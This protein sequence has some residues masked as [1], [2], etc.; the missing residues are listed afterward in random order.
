[1]V[2]K[3]GDKVRYK[4]PSCG[5]TFVVMKIRGKWVTIGTRRGNGVDYVCETLVDNLERV[6]E[7]S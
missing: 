1:M 4:N 7:A 2:F 6:E 5:R 3:K